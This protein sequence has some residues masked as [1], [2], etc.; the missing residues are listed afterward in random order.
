MN[1]RFLETLI[2]LAQLRSVR[3]TARAMHAT[4]AA[5]SLRIKALEEELQTEL[6]DRSTR[7]FRLTPNA[8][9]L[10][11]HAKAVVDATRRLRE[12]ART[13]SA[14]RGR[15]RLGVIETVVHSWLAHSVRQLNASFPELEIDLVVDMSTT[16]EKRLLAGE[17]DLVVGIEGVN[18]SEITSEPLAV[19]PVRWIARAGLLAP[20]RE[21]LAQRLLQFPI[22]TFGRGTQPHRMLEDIVTRLANLSAVPLEQTRITC[23]PSVAAIIQLI[24]NGFGVAAIPW[25]FVSSHLENGEFVVVPLQPVPPPIIVSMSRRT[26]APVAVHAAASAV[27][28][29]CAEY[30]AQVDGR[31][32]ESLG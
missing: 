19:Y 6:I 16:L 20:Q 10:L 14:V 1:T 8:D 11:N 4:P 28:A 15:L 18:S 29:A 7:E 31:Y 30:C 17:L 27:R 21:G 12:A 13:E 3:A 22:L 5:I 26:N 24:R 9:Y 2:T 23:S 32:I 25:L